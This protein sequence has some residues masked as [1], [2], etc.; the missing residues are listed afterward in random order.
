MGSSPVHLS[1]PVASHTSSFLPLIFF[2]GF[3]TSTSLASSGSNQI[4]IPPS[5][6]AHTGQDTANPPPQDIRRLSFRKKLV[7]GMHVAGYGGVMAALATAWYKNYERTGLH[8]F[9]DSREWLQIDKVG[10]WYG[11]WIECRAGNELWRWAGMEKKKRIWISA[12]SAFGFQTAIEFLDGFSA[13]WGWS[14]SDFA[15]NVLG[16]GTFAAQEY[17]WDDQKIKLKWSFHKRNYKDPSLQNRSKELFGSTFHE[18]L[19]KDYNTHT[20]WVSAP[21]NLLIKNKRLPDWL[22]ISVGYGAD[23]MFGGEENIARDANGNI[24]FD[25]R[26]IK[27][28]RQWYLAPDIDLSKIKTRSKALN[29]ALTVLSAFKF[30][31][32]SLEFSNGRFKLNALHF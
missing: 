29:F 6:S 11:T 16:I 18:R 27:R 22:C 9:N 23:G 30:P 12:A 10:H 13:K 4:Q 28:I 19:F 31:A 17:V 21:L 32:P 14:W 8:A 24:I 25:R 2:I 7:A 5:Y 26:D 20:Y 3:I 1:S 15:A